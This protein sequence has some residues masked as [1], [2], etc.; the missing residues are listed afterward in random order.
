M[1]IENQKGRNWC[2]TGTNANI[3]EKRTPCCQCKRFLKEVVPSQPL[4]SEI[5][6]VP[7]QQLGPAFH[8]QTKIQLNQIKMSSLD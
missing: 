3:Q 1:N 4:L 7:R 2:M 5:V 8:A 6:P